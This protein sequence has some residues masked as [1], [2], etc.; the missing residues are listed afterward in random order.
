MC[1]GWRTGRAA[2]DALQCLTGGTPEQAVEGSHADHVVSKL[3]DALPPRSYLPKKNTGT[4]ACP[5]IAL[6]ALYIPYNE[7]AIL[8]SFERWT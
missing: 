3:C 6:R 7:R 4:A 2:I 5:Q 1:C 8:S